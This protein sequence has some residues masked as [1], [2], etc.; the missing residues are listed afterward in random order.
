MFNSVLKSIIILVTFFS[1]KFNAYSQSIILESK[2]QLGIDITNTLTFL[3]KNNQSYLLNYKYYFNKYRFAV[4]AGLNLELSTGESEGYYPDIR[5][6]I[7][8]N[9]FD[10]NWNKYFG[11]DLSYSYFKSNTV[12][13]TTQRFGITPLIGVE[14]YFN[15]RISFSTEAA[16]NFNYFLINYLNTFEPIKTKS[17]SNVNIGYIGMFVISYHF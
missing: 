6:G 17:Y 15:K 12:D 8:K 10:E 13:I 9:K 14:H 4:R 2:H 7:Q 16:I 3:K 11:V 5:I 1:I